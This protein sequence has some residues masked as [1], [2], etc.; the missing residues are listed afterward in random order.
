VL[1]EKP[2]ANEDKM[3]LFFNVSVNVVPTAIP[4]R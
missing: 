2:H 4:F 3:I 1:R